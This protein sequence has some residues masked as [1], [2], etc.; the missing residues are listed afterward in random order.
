[1]PFKHLLPSVSERCTP[2]ISESRYAALL[3]ALLVSTSE[4]LVRNSQVVMSDALAALLVVVCLPLIRRRTR[5]SSYLLGLVAGYAFVIRESGL[6]VVVCALIVVSGWNRLRVI[7]AAAVPILGLAT[8]NW[9]T[10]GA[11]WRTGYNYW[12]GAVRVYSLSYVLRHPWR[13]SDTYYA[14][15]LHLFHL[16]GHIHG[17]YI[18]LVPNL[19]FYPLIVLGFS[20]VFGPPWVSLIGLIAAGLRWRLVE[21]QFTLLLALLTAVF[22]MP[23]LGQDARYMAGPCILLTAWASAAVVELAREVRTRNRRQTAVLASPT[24]SLPRTK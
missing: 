24:G 9:S 13:A 23:N 20:T 4:F 21:A 17:G 3:A 15:S 19:W 10:F 22:Y 1:M 11:P 7:V 6:I 18:A 12:L 16:L 14:Y 2:L 8:Y 5:G